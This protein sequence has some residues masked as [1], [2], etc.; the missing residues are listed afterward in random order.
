[1]SYEAVKYTGELVMI[2]QSDDRLGVVSRCCGEGITWKTN[3]LGR[4]CTPLCGQCHTAVGNPKLEV[5]REVDIATIILATIRLWIS[6]WLDVDQLD[7]QV[8][9]S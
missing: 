2:C 5:V 1:M 6:L 3:G 4:K 8:T 9:I 7:V